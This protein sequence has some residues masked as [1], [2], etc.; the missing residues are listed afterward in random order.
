MADQVH[1]Y[2][3][4]VDPVVLAEQEQFVM[5]TMEISSN[6]SAVIEPTYSLN[7][8]RM[9]GMRVVDIAAGG[10]D[11]TARFCELGADAVAI[12]PSYD[13]R[14]IFVA[15]SSEFIEFLDDIDEA[16]RTARRQS[17]PPNVIIVDRPSVK[18]DQ[19]RVTNRSANARFLEDWAAHPER[20]ITGSAIDLPLPD[21][22]ADLVLNLNFLSNLH[23][24]LPEF[25]LASVW[26]GIRVLRRSGSMKI[27]LFKET[28]DKQALF[29]YHDT[30]KLEVVADAV[31]KIKETGIK[32][33]MARRM[34]TSEAQF[35]DITRKK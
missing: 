22:S 3:G 28:Q 12:D 23:G 21:R 1:I 20:Y 2:D 30:D 34:L 11:L 10:S 35:L 32:V 13:D 7:P 18:N 16:E 19:P 5:S 9:R 6:A 25:A 31:E 4:F 33:S 17:L 15:R 24:I 14:G 27:G 29:Q 8:E 26:E